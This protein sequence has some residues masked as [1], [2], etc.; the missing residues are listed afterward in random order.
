MHRDVFTGGAF[1][2]ECSYGPIKKKGRESNNPRPS[3]NQLSNKSLYFTLIVVVPL[4]SRDE[5]PTSIS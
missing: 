1:T 2:G 4:I 3:Q 5:V